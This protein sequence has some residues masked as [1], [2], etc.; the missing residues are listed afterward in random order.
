VVSSEADDA[1]G[2]EMER[3][4]T[5]RGDPGTRTSGLRAEQ[6]ETVVPN[7]RSNLPRGRCVSN[8]RARHD[9][10]VRTTPVGQL[11]TLPGPGA[12]RFGYHDPLTPVWQATAYRVVREISGDC[13]K[14]RSVRPRS[15]ICIA[16]SSAASEPVVTDQRARSRIGQLPVGYENEGS[17]AATARIRQTAYPW[18]DPATSPSRHRRT[19]C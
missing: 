16:V 13:A 1:A 18:H 8:G 15:L 12:R 11:T 14:Q 17:T 5:M 4:R 3:P 10:I 9:S 2:S 19:A 7:L 6:D